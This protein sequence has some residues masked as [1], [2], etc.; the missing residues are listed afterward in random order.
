MDLEGIMFS[1]IK[2]GRERHCDITYMWNLK[3]HINVHAK[4]TYIYRNK[5]VVARE[6]GKDKL[7]I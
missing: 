3:I 5:L 4:Q 1:E 7:E 6:R 2:S